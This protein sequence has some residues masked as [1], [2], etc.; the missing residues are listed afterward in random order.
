V[1]SPVVITATY[2]GNSRNSPSVGT[3]SLTVTGKTTKMR[4]SCAPAGFREFT[5]KARVIG[6][7]P[8]G[9]VTWSQI[10][11]GSVS[12]IPASC[13][14]VKGTCSVTVI[15]QTSGFVTLFAVYNGDSYNYGSSATVSIKIK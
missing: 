4:L 1:G 5:C 9:V 8:T 12:F 3:Y 14:L 15:G 7:S 11:A 10:G 13:A 6:Y 2:G